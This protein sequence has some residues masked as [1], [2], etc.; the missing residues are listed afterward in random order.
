MDR[1]KQEFLE[2]FQF[3]STVLDAFTSFSFRSPRENG[4]LDGSKKAESPGSARSTP[5]LKKDEKDKPATPTSKPM[6]PGYPFP[7]GLP[8]PG[9]FNGF[10]PPLSGS[11]D[12]TRPLPPGLLGG[13]P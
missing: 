3:N 9:V 1:G 6:L 10:R 13:K 5:N 2:S 11:V 7:D 12:P 8:P 4:S